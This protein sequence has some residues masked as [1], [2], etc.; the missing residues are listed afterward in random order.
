MKPQEY[1]VGMIVQACDDLAMI[2]KITDTSVYLLLIK[3]SSS[4]K[5]ELAGETI[6]RVRHRFE[7]HLISGAFN[8]IDLDKIILESL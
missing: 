8:L 2:S 5:H 3:S 1:K 7:D 4:M 6:E